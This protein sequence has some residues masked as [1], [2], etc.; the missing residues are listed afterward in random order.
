V[1]ATMWSDVD[2]KATMGFEGSDEERDGR[3]V[4]EV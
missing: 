2:H 1:R 3:V 4:E